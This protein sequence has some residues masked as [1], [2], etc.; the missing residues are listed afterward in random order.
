MALSKQ[1]GR[2]EKKSRTNLL[3]LER[4]ESEQGEITKVDGFERCGRVGN[5]SKSTK[6]RPVSF[7]T[8]SRCKSDED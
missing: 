5:L 1:T 3:R 2:E 4:V 6:R 7:S 8:F